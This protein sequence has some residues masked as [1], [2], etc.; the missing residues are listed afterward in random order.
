MGADW[1]RW[2]RFSI[3]DQRWQ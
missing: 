2:T 1:N 3:W